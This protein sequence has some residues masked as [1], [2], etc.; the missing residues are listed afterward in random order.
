MITKSLISTFHHPR[1]TKF[2][3]L[4][5]WLILKFNLDGPKKIRSPKKV[6]ELFY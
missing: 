5:S 2:G 1:I 3:T 4:V 6:Q